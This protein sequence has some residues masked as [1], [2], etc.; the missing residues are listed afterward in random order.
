MQS[1]SKGFR[2]CLR[3]RNDQEVARVQM[4]AARCCALSAMFRSDRF[5]TILIGLKHEARSSA[6]FA[7]TIRSVLKKLAIPTGAQTL[8]GRRLS[9]VTVGECVFLCVGISDLFSEA[10]PTGKS[11]AA[12][13]S[14][15]NVSSA[16]G[17]TKVVVLQER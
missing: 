9:L 14:T 3:L 5:T 7:R 4:W 2:A 15:C 6:S 8:R 16:D 10:E 1:A 13:S 17:D 12:Q 11:G